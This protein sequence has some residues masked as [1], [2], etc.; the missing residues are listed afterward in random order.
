MSELL[1]KPKLDSVGEVIET[2]ID[3]FKEI[4]ELQ[5]IE[6][7]YEKQPEG[8]RR[9]LTVDGN[10]F[11][12]CDTGYE[13]DG[14]TFYFS[15][16]R[17]NEILALVKSK[18]Q[19]EYVIRAFR[20]SESDRQWKACPGYRT[21]GSGYLK[22]DEGHPSHHYVQSSKLDRRLYELIQMQP[23]ASSEEKFKKG[24]YL[25]RIGKNG[26]PPEREEEFE[27]S[28][29]N[30]EFKSD[31]W[32]EVQNILQFMLQMQTV[33]GNENSSKGISSKDPIGQFC[34][35]YAGEF[36][37][38]KKIKAVYEELISV[39]GE[40]ESKKISLEVLKD[41]KESRLKDFLDSYETTL[42]TFFTLSQQ[43]VNEKM[44]KS[45]M[46]PEFS[47]A[48]KRGEYMKGK[49]KIEEFNHVSPEGDHIVF[50]M[51]SDERGRVY[52][53]NVFDPSVPI[54]SYGTPSLKCNMG[55]L[56]YK[57]IDYTAQT[58]GLPIVKFGNDWMN[59]YKDISS[60]WKNFEV[61]KRYKDFLK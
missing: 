31:K 30:V 17:G 40:E 3:F 56:V 21:N 58:F 19:E 1:I 45:N 22:G 38:T 52:V 42:R 6:E 34:L 53:D 20:M 39:I 47:E 37:E 59:R 10:A 33:L 12:S 27:F 36:E 25:P 61:V 29:E 26:N 16:K 60:Y 48:T 50:A 35:H 7:R 43:L 15:E 54:D 4:H 8:V 49:I 11:G 51:A 5:D 41:S 32:K 13:I 18:G 55:I 28:E 57:P 2:K 24:M 46:V 44:L 9:V 14:I 23:Q